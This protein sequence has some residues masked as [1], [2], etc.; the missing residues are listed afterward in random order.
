NPNARVA[1]ITDR[2][3]L[4]KQIK[5]AVPPLIAKWKPLIGVKVVRFY[6]QRM[7]TKWGSCRQESGSIRL[8]TELA[9]K[10]PQCLEYIV[11]H[12]MV[13]LVERTH[14]ERFTA[15]MDQSLPHWRVLRTELN[16]WPLTHEDWSVS[17]KPW[18]QCGHWMK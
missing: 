1:I 5:Q 2:D 14:N 10:P 16:R 13:H 15:L 9:K 18:Q 6:A 12:E 4:D 8:N 7:K 3:E 11:V 17:G